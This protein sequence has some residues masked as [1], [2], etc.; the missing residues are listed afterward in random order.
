MDG[1]SCSECAIQPLAFSHIH[2]AHLHIKYSAEEGRMFQ[3][4]SPAPHK[5]EVHIKCVLNARITA[6]PAP[7]GAGFPGPALR[8]GL[9]S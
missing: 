1:Y 2:N 8:P 4:E 9:P 5:E 7:P 3:F 6:Q